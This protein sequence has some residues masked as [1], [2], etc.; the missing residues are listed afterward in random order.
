MTAYVIAES[1]HADSPEVRAYR[2]VAQASI[3]RHGGRYLARGALPEAMEGTWGEDHRMVVIEFPSLEQ[4]KAWYTS[5]EY[6]EA[7]ATRSDLEGRRILFVDGV[8]GPVV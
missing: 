8:T 3:A 6:T 2:E 7:R 4:A 5:P 1:R